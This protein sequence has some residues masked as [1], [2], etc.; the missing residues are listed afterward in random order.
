MPTK[1]PW[2]K[3]EVRQAF[4]YAINRAA[5]VQNVFQGRAHVLYNPPGFKV[6]DDLQKY[7]YNVDTAKQLLQAGGWPSCISGIIPATGLPFFIAWR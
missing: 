1:A 5:I 3:K 6:Y 7:D 2:D 4:Y